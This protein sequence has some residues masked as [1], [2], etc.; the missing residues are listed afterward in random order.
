MHE[1]LW[2]SR[3]ALKKSICVHHHRGADGSRRPPSQAPPAPA[4]LPRLPPQA[5]SPRAAP[6]GGLPVGGPPRRPPRGRQQ[7]HL[8]EASVTTSGPHGGQQG[9]SPPAPLSGQESQPFSCRRGVQVRAPGPGPPPG[10]LA[11]CPVG[12]GVHTPP[13]FQPR[14]G[15][16]RLSR[17]VL[18]TWVVS[19]S[20]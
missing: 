14:G 6:P 18:P 16:L 20:F 11:C 13:G 4:W 15:L 7:L 19:G 9:S 8:R 5:A 10:G 12:R 17:R 1:V 3:E 2:G